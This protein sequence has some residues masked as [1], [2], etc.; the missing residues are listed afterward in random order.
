VQWQFV[1]R[2]TESPKVTIDHIRED[3]SRARGAAGEAIV[4]L[5]AATAS[6]RQQIMLLFTTPRL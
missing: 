3:A 5:V 4:P 1:P 6:V 2:G